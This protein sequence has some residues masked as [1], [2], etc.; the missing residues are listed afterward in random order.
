MKTRVANGTHLKDVAYEILEDMIVR[1]L[2]AGGTILSE[3]ELAQMI[4]VGRTPVREALQRLAEIGL[5]VILPQRGVM[6]VQVT[7]ALQLQV[8]EIRRPLERLVASCAARRA[9]PAQRTAM[10]DMAL[11]TEASA[12]TGDG[13]GFLLM[14]RRN[15]AALEEAAC[16]ELIQNVMALLHARSRRFWYAHYER[17]GDLPAAGAAHA[18][19]LRSISVGDEVQALKNADRLMDYLEE[20]CRST[21]A[22]YSSHSGVSGARIQI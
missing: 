9:T 1:G 15:H 17:F 5:V 14:T 7:V 4:N 19:L 21:I 8:L 18:A 20:F 6:I 11:A 22:P 12:A 10:L 13:E 3:A 16:N 2:I